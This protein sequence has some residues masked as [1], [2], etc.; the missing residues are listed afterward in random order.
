MVV[1][2]LSLFSKYDGILKEEYSAVVLSM[3]HKDEVPLAQDLTLL[4]DATL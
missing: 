2:D 3:V 4:L 1:L